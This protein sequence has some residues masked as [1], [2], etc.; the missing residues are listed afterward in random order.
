MALQNYNW[1]HKTDEEGTSRGF[2]LGRGMGAAFTTALSRIFGDK[3]SDIETN[4]QN[5][6]TTTIPSDTSS[7]VNEAVDTDQTD[8]VSNAVNNQEEPSETPGIEGSDWYKRF[9]ENNPELGNVAQTIGGVMPGSHPDSEELKL[10]EGNVPDYFEGKEGFIPDYLQGREGF[11]PDYIQGNW[12]ERLRSPMT[13]N[14]AQALHESVVP[15]V[16]EAGKKIKEVHGNIVNKATD[17]L[18]RATN[19]DWPDRFQ[20][21]PFDL[22]QA[23][24][25][26]EAQANMEA[27]DQVSYPPGSAGDAEMGE[28]LFERD[29]YA[30]GET[31]PSA[32]QEALDAGTYYEGETEEF[33]GTPYDEESEKQAFFETIDAN[34]MAFYKSMSPEASEEQILEQLWKMKQSG[35]QLPQVPETVFPPVGQTNEGAA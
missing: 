18:V 24:L 2:K 33:E 16:K 26:K 15:G 31:T 8:V 13:D 20:G 30:A 35:M 12:A 22:R 10:R 14:I 6:N 27:E 1:L 5:K 23:M 7:L 21:E 19:A 28:V 3:T 32:M 4:K 29:K 11:I 34:Q 17:W 9:E 25:Q